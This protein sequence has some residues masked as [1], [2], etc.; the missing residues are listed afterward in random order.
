[1]IDEAYLAYLRKRP[2]SL[3]GSPP[4][5]DAHHLRNRGTLE[6]KRLDETATAACRRCHTLIHT[7]GLERALQM[8][9]MKVQQLITIITTDLVSYFTK[10]IVETGI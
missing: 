7:V 6:H 3:C 9:G 10:E 2:C 1:V 4:L 5:N 8:K